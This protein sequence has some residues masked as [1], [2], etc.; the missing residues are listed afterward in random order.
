MGDR[1][2]PC[3]ECHLRDPGIWILKK[4]FRFGDPDLRQILRERE[5]RRFS[6]NLTEIEDT[7][8]ELRSD[9]THVKVLLLMLANELARSSNDGRLYLG[10][11]RCFLLKHDA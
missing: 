6:K 2:K 8:I 3:L 5:S 11:H 10:W 7:H 1:L 9:I 4:I